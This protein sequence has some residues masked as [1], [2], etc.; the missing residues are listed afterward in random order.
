MLVGG[1]NPS[2]NISQLELLFPI[3]GK[4]CSKPLTSMVW[5][6]PGLTTFHHPI[7]GS[8]PCV[9]QNEFVWWDHPPMS[10]SPR[11]IMFIRVPLQQYPLVVYPSLLW[12]TVDLPTQNDDFHWFSIAKYSNAW[13]KVLNYQGWSS[14]NVPL[15]RVFFHKTTAGWP[16]STDGVSERIYRQY[17][18]PIGKSTTYWLRL[19]KMGVPMISHGVDGSYWIMVVHTMRGSRKTLPVIMQRIQLRQAINGQWAWAMN[20]RNCWVRRHAER[21]T[22]LTSFFWHGNAIKCPKP[23]NARKSCKMPN[24]ITPVMT[25]FTTPLQ[26][27]LEDL[28]SPLRNVNFSLHG[29][30]LF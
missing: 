27:G 28:F 5:G 4:K 20:G 25:G 11:F 6:F 16:P 23:K 18:K 7:L 13:K 12:K 17:R 3:Y 15:E 14:R 30:P 10:W 8:N 22:F 24:V 29:P 9:F 19:V 1:F 21:I 2:E 26:R